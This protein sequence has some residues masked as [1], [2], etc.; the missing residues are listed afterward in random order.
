MLPA[1]PDV[2]AG[3]R[4]FGAPPDDGR[5]AVRVLGVIAFDARRAAAI[6]GIGG[7]PARVVSLGAPIGAARSS[8]KCAARSIVV[9]RNGLRREI[10]CPRPGTPTR[11]CADTP[12]TAPC[13]SAR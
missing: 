4:L 12:I 3:A 2:A 6:V 9:E 8:P 1:P 7:E 11:S 10:R 13:C 5:D